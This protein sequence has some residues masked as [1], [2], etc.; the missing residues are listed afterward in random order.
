MS[1]IKPRDHP[2]TEKKIKMQRIYKRANGRF[3]QCGWMCPDC[4]HLEND[5]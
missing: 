5:D 1:K 2:H 3:V 4:G